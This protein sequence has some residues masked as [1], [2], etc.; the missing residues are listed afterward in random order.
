ME[1]YTSLIFQ[2]SVSCSSFP[3]T[4]LTGGFRRLCR[5][6]AQKSSSSSNL[7]SF[8]GSVNLGSYSLQMGRWSKHQLSISRGRSVFSPMAVGSVII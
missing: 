4:L 1:V 8:P 7:C 2:D 3:T 5:V 6:Q